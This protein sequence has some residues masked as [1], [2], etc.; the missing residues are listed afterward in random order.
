MD[1]YVFLDTWAWRALSNRKDEHHEPAK[2]EYKEIN[3]AGY[4]TLSKEQ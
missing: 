2:K 1:S 4:R 3:A